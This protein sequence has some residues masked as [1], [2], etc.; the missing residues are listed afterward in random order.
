M[1]EITPHLGLPL[2]APTNNAAEDALRLR[3]ALQMIDA[4]VH[5]TTTAIS[6]AVDQVNQ[7]LTARIEQSQAQIE[8]LIATGVNDGTF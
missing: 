1:T 6:Q 7:D 3:Q 2:V 8:Q 4:A 5:D